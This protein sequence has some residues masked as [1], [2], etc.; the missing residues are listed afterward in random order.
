LVALG[1][2]RESPTALQWMLIVLGTFGAGLLMANLHGKRTVV[3]V[4][5]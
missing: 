3:T 5:R 4:T 2:T 1:I